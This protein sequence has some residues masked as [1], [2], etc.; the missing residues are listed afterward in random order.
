MNVD[1]DALRWFQLV[2]DGMTVTE[3]SEVYAVSQPGVSRALARL[4]AELG[5]PLF[6]RSGRLLRLTHAGAAFKRHVDRLVNDL[7]DGLAAVDELVDPERGVVTVAFPLSLGTWLIPRLIGEFGRTHPRVRFV[8]PRTAVGEAGRA[9]GLLASRAADLEITTHRLTGADL[10]WRRFAIEPLL[11]AVPLSHPLAGRDVASL[12]D[13]RDERFILRRAP[14]GM[15]TQV[16]G[17]CAAAGFEPEVA[18]EVDDL[19][20][21]R[22]FVAAGLG[23]SVVPSM[24]ITAPAAV[25]GVRHL[26]LT[27]PGAQRDLGLAWLSGR[28][29]LPSA[30][31]FRRFVLDHGAEVGRMRD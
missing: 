8:L 7:D 9:S 6:Q 29:R 30:E 15:R 28:G 4:E 17:L 24:G 18:F 3:V 27:D 1:T 16:L 12:A 5:T 11:L 25:A 26:P 13:V 22:G 23:V 10:R 31:A 19:P 14:S 2:A 20:T 21:V